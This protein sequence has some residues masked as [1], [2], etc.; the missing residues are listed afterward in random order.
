MEQSQSASF[1]LTAQ[2]C[3]AATTQSSAQSLSL[4]HYHTVHRAVLNHSHYNTLILPTNIITVT[5]V[6]AFSC[7]TAG[8]SNQSQHQ[9]T[10][11]WWDQS[12]T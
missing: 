5:S 7:C 12:E 3:T 4:Q 10:E 8:L 9:G 1:L 2:S 6:L 11:P